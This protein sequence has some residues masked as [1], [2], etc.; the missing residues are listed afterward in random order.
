MNSIQWERNVP[1]GETEGR[2]DGQTDR[3]IHDEANSRYSQFRE[4]V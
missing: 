3:Q 2:A 1:C 4:R